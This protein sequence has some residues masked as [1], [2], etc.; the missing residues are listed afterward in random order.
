V[1][2]P[3]VSGLSCSKIAALQGNH[4]G[5]AQMDVSF[6]NPYAR[7]DKQSY[8]WL[9]GN[10][11]AHTTR[12]DGH[13]QPQ[14]VLD[15]YAKLGYQFF[16]LSDHDVLADYEGLDGR[17]MILLRGNEVSRSGF[18]ILHVHAKTRIHP[19]PDRQKVIDDI[20]ADGGLAI[21]NHPNWTMNFNHI[22]YDKLLELK[23]YVGI[24][25][26]NGVTRRGQ[27]T[28]FAVD[29][30]DRLLSAGRMVWGFA[31]DDSHAVTGDD[32]LGWNVVQVR[33]DQQT[34]AGVCEA[35]RNGYFYASTGV[36]IEVIETVGAKLKII[37]PNAQA[38]EVIG[39]HGSRL[40]YVESGELN[41]DAAGVTGPFVRV[42]CYGIGD[43]MAWTQPFLI[44]GGPAERMRTLT[45]ERPVMK[46]LRVENT[47]P[48]NGDEQ[49]VWQKAP[50]AA[51]F[52]R[53]PDA[54]TPEVKTT[55][56]CVVSPTHLA[57]SVHC[58]EPLMAKLKTQ[59]GD[60]DPNL[61]A[62]DGIELFLDT[63]ASGVRYFHLQTNAAGKFCGAHSEQSAQ[64]KPQIKIQRAKDAWTLQLAVEFASLGVQVPPKPGT[65][66]GF[67]LCRNRTTANTHY[68]FTWSGGSNH[69]PSAYGWLEF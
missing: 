25:I 69:N 19:S 16:Q 26:F 37:A 48:I 60:D 53:H 30:W 12:S 58:D 40:T 63:E 54:S 59:F 18:H 13:R 7:T 22:P 68:L 46:T 41:F 50:A 27:G 49:G 43:R 32:A 67:Q 35:L 10:L 51:T 20:L 33:A 42:Q 38:I 15:T 57:F 34:P 24:E 14:D 62:D 21:M 8:V 31:H 17:G 3:L 45:A 65:R 61:W 52:Y 56:R 66:W 6:G 11:H 29:K 44:R 55:A 2:V 4:Q 5:D 36:N 28:P 39:E 47:P 64:I 23:N 1:K 9:R